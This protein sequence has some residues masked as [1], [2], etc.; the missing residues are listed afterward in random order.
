MCQIYGEKVTNKNDTIVKLKPFAPKLVSFCFFPLTFY[1]CLLST[2]SNPDIANHQRPNLR[3][4]KEK[5]GENE[6]KENFRS[7]RRIFF[8]FWWLTAFFSFPQKY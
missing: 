2:P 8:A 5:V 7:K 6:K 3:G 1:L 4:A